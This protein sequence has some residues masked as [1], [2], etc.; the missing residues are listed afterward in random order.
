MF[1]KGQ[2]VYFKEGRETKVGIVI[3]FKTGIKKTISRDGR[4]YAMPQSECIILTENGECSKPT[5]EL[6]LGN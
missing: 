1:T 5:N 4:I 2:K 3:D 6:F